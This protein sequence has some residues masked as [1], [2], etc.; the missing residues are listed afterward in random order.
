MIKEIISTAVVFFTPII[1]LMFID[2]LTGL[3]KAFKND[4]K[5]SSAKLRGTTTKSIIY[6]M[7]LVIGGCLTAVGEPSV[8]KAFAIF[9]GV[10]EG[11]SILEN[12]GE[13]YP[14]LHVLDKLRQLLKNKEPKA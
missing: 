3:A 14:S 13:M 1:I 4:H 2:L 11:V 6:F 8:G 12:V 5:I 10:V 7:V 9:I